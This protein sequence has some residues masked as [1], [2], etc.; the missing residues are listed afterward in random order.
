MHMCF[1]E[2][3]GPISAFHLTLA[4]VISWMG[5]Y[6][7]VFP[8]WFIS[9]ARLP[10]P[11]F[12]TVWVDVT[13]FCAPDALILYYFGSLCAD[14]GPHL[15]DNCEQSVQTVTLFNCRRHAHGGSAHGG[16]GTLRPLVKFGNW[17]MAKERVER[18]SRPSEWVERSPTRA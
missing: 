11:V 15:H 7:T 1:G 6:E 8:T 5:F 9:P 10:Q 17:T 2:G 18:R 14:F 12:F 13:P 3:G 4:G 16:S